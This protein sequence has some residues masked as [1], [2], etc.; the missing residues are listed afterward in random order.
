MRGNR[1]TEK[2]DNVPNETNHRGS[3]SFLLVYFPGML[4]PLG[5]TEGSECVVFV[6]LAA[7]SDLIVRPAKNAANQLLT[8]YLLVEVLHNF[9]S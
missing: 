9:S 7:G 6:F 1:E 3:A 8:R 5:G 2:F 4:C